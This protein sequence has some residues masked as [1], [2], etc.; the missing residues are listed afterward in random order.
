MLTSRV[1]A[2]AAA[3]TEPR[4]EF[5][6]IVVGAGSSGCVVANRLSEDRDVSVLLLEAGGPDNDPRLR[7]FPAEFSTL[8]GT[9]FDW[10]YATEPEKNLNSRRI[11]WPRG[12]LLGG[13]SSINGMVYIRGHREDY[14]HWSKLGN[15]GWAYDNVLPL[16]MKSESNSRFEGEYHGLNGLM[17]VES[18]LDN[19][20]IKEAM[21]RS[22]EGHGF[23]TDA[24]WDFNAGEQAGTAGYYQFQIKDGERHS[25]ASAFLTPFLDRPNLAARPWSLAS[26]L[27]WEGNRIVGVEYVSNEW[28]V[29][30]VRA[31]REVV[32]SAG[33]IDSPQLLML[34]GIGPASELKQQEIPVKC[35][36]P[37]VGQNLQ[38]H[39]CVSIVFQP[40]R[41]VL[42]QVRGTGGLFFHSSQADRQDAPDLQCYWS[43]YYTK[44]P[45]G[46]F[47]KSG[48]WL[49]ASLGLPDSRGTI[50]LRSANPLDKPV[51]RA[52]YLQSQRDM[53]R[54]VEGFS[55]LREAVN[56]EA[57]K[58]LIAKEI[59]PGEQTDAETAIRQN[60]TTIFHPV[61]T[62]KMG[63]DAMSVVDPQ[64]RVRGI[65]GLRIAD[66]SIMPRIINGNTNA[67]C[68]MIGE[69]A[70]ELIKSDGA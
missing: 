26:R 27:L 42:P 30:T 56:G 68:I 12:R 61:G 35:E 15:T 54:L 8:L 48:L 34:S 49:C 45:L 2:V 66:A 39:V 55:F 53:P 32:V 21:F 33:V 28:D 37:G 50:T 62:C 64:L 67:P 38:D 1:R 17:S 70:A 18:V 10:K 57:F 44:N 69:K 5:D 41:E 65:D 22:V 25:A 19:S 24:T 7:K 52:N 13:T 46:T 47:S 9:K 60:G 29:H 36:L 6:Y 58:G 31:R 14:D 16:F 4:E 23:K 40:S 51:I 3:H 63:T 43:D 11:D 20:E 59:T